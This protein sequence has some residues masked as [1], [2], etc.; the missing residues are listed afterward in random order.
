MQFSNSKST[1][2]TEITFYASLRDLY[3]RKDKKV[4]PI[5]FVVYV[6]ILR[7]KVERYSADEWKRGVCEYFIDY[8]KEKGKDI[9]EG[10]F[11]EENTLT[12]RTVKNIQDRNLE[13]LY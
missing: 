3:V 7:E 10:N 5:I 6:V 1:I 13:S 2:I 8:R 9:K 4:F 11:D 12:V